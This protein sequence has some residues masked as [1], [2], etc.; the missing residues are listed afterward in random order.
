[1]V[2][3]S[4]RIAGAVLA[5][6]LLVTACGG[7]DGDGTTSEPATAGDALV[8]TGLDTLDFDADE[9]TATAGTVEFEYQLQGVLEH[10]LVV[11][12]REDDMRLVVSGGNSDQGSIDLDPGAY[13]LY[14]DIAGHR[15]GGM[16]ATLVVS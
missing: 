2:A 8:V 6:G 15:E 4:T 11:E 7:D 3:I 14:C 10:T 13:V 5:G 16:E 1:M 12:G 9:Y